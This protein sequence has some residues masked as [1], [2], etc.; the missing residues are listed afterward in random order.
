VAF[1][2][3]LTVVIESAVENHPRIGRMRWEDRVYSFAR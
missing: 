3:A 2:P 1:V